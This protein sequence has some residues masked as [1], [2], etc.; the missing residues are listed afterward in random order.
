MYKRQIAVFKEVS[1]LHAR[2]AGMKDP[3]QV[4]SEFEKLSPESKEALAKF[5]NEQAKE[6]LAK[7]EAPDTT[8]GLPEFARELEA[9]KAA[10]AA[11]AEKS[12]DE[13]VDGE[14]E[15]ESGIG[16][17]SY[18]HLDVYKRQVRDRQGARREHAPQGRG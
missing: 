16:A 2:I 5:A 1:D 8:G 6:A 13:P 4:Q 3:Q 10:A 11:V 7:K 17:V 9:E 18:T 12:D 15:K 14:V